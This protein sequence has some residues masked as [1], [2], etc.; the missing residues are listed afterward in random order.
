MVLTSPGKSWNLKKNP[1]KSRNLKKNPGKS[2]NLKK[3]PGKSRNFA[4]I[5]EKSWKSPAIFLW[6]NSPKERIL[7]KQQHFSGFLCMLNLAVH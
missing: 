7:S 2:R 5:L 1:G 3:N 6:S 4:E